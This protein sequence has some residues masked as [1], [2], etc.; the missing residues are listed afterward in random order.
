MGSV[1][2]TA[3]GRGAR[4]KGGCIAVEGDLALGPWAV[5]LLRLDPLVTMIT[6]IIWPSYNHQLHVEGY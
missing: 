2:R 3:I 5:V 6:T 4:H 1:T